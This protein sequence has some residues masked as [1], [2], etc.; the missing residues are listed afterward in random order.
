MGCIFDGLRRAFEN[1]GFIDD[2]TQFKVFLLVQTVE[3]QI[4][5]GI[6]LV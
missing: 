3:I 5:V 6:D 4:L 1:L 2:N